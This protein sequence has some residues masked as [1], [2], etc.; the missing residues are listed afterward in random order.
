[1]KMYETELTSLDLDALKEWTPEWCWPVMDLYQFSKDYYRDSDPWTFF[2]DLVGYNEEHYG[3][4]MTDA[5][6][7]L[8]Y[9]E[10]DALADALKV[11]ADRPSDAERWVDAVENFGATDEEI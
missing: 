10:M 1:M 5:D 7:S 4:K 9:M 3:E 6:F 11:W 8:G 2:L